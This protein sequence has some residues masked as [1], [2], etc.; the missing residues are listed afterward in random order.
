MTRDARSALRNKRIINDGEEWGWDVAGDADM[1]GM[2]VRTRMWMGMVMGME[3]V[4]PR[5]HRQL[6]HHHRHRIRRRRIRR[7]HRRRRHR[8]APRCRSGGQP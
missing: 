1:M 2:A 7:R 8:P 3:L 5:H 4:T 6:H